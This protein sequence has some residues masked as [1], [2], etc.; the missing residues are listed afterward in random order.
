MGLSWVGGEYASIGKRDKLGPFGLIG[1]RR[2]TM[3]HII[4]RRVGED[5]G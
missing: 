2:R 4:G 1:G 5:L 3:H